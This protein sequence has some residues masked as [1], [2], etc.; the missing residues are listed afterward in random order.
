MHHNRA[1]ERPQP[2]RQVLRTCL[3]LADVGMPVPPLQCYDGGA[4]S[5][6]QKNSAPEVG[7][8]IMC[9]C[10]EATLRVDPVTRAVIAHTPKPTPKTFADMEAAARAMR[11]QDVRKES[12]FRQSVEAERNKADLMEKKFAEAVKKA[13][14]APDLSKP[15]LRDFDLE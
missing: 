11:E 7:F 5:K 9:P 4:M 2:E 3:Y 12:I 15:F 8:E 13:K 1:A 10:C 6:K 14:E